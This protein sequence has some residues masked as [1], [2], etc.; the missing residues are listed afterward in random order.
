MLLTTFNAHKQ[1]I[2]EAMQET[3]T[4]SKHLNRPLKEYC[5]IYRYETVTIPQNED[6]RDKPLEELLN[7]L[8]ALREIPNSTLSMDGYTKASGRY[9]YFDRVVYT[10]KITCIRDSINPSQVED[11]MK[12]L[13]KKAIGL[14]SYQHLDCKVMKLYK[15]SKI[16]WEEA[17]E[18]MLEEC[19]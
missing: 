18:T 6:D 16:T 5:I 11:A 3:L 13:V 12:V 4:L 9:D 17:K 8:N 10:A 14:K 1:G 7:D 15:Q 2:A 19:S